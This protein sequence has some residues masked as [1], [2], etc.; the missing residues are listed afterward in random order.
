QVP[1]RMRQLHPRYGT[2]WVGILLFSAIAALTLIPGQA[3][4]LGNL[5]AFGAMLSF[6]IAHISVTRLRITRPDVQRPYR[7]PGN[8]RVRGFALPLFAV[9]GGLG[10]F[11]S[12]VVVAALH[13]SVAIAGIGWLTVGMIV[14]PLYRHRHGLDLS[15]TVTVAIPKPVV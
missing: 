8:V 2:P 3:T 9:F 1:D 14:Y 13:A 6:T 12:L 15:S 7:P 4:F 5:Y 11:A 10:T